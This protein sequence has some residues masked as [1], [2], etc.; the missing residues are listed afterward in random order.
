MLLQVGDL[1]TAGMQGMPIH[2]ITTEQRYK[3]LILDGA[4]CRGLNHHG[5]T[6]KG[7]RVPNSPRATRR[8]TANRTEAMLILSTSP[9][10]R[11]ATKDTNGSAHRIE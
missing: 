3:S 9:I 5:R 4:G 11:S 8:S 2:Y 7:G 10:C 1:Y 6:M